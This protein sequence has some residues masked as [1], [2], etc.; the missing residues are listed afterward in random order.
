MADKK[1]T[2]YT[3]DEDVI[4]RLNVRA[5]QLNVSKSDLVERLLSEGLER[6]GA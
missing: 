6:E 2:S 1:R 5:A 3:L 4:I